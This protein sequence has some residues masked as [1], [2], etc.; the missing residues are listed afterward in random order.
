MKRFFLSPKVL[1]AALLLVLSVP[2]LAQSLKSIAAPEGYYIG[3][4]MSNELMNNTQTDNGNIDAIVSTEY[5][6]LVLE[7]GM[8]MDQ[9]L[10]NRPADPFNVTINDIS[11]TNIDNFVNYANQNGMRTRGHAMIWYNQAPQ[12]L[13]NEAPSWSAQN[14]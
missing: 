3:N 8:K 6:I 2:M 5:N 4:I 9:M 1:T 13:L 10:P 11:T 14:V 7:N 12:W